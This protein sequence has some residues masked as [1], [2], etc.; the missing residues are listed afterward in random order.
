MPVF[1]FS[2]HDYVD[3]L[4]LARQAIDEI[5]LSHPDSTP[6]NVKAV[7]MSPWKSHLVN[8]KF[9]PLCELVTRIGKQVS[10]EHLKA[11]L[12]ALNLDLKVTDCWGVIYETSDHTVPHHHYPSDL[13][14]VIYLDADENCAPIIFG[15]GVAVNPKPN[16]LVIFPGILMHEVPQNTA[17]RTVIAMNLQKF[18]HFN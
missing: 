12:D 4:L 17:K 11:K 6:S 10:E 15:D 16:L 18:P 1:W 3:E 7:Y 8:P 5:R 14:A 2:L 13:S 9:G